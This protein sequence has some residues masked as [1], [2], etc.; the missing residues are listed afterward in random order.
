MQIFIETNSEKAITLNVVSFDT[1]E[2]VKEKF[3]NVRNIPTDQQHLF[4]EGKKLS[5]NRS[6]DHY[7]I[8]DQSTLVLKIGKSMIIFVETGYDKPINLDVLP[9]DTIADVK[10]MVFEERGIVSAQQKLYFAGQNLED[11]RTLDSYSIE[12][13][14]TLVLRLG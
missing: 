6:L 9:T 3:Q 10:S 14:S 7:G 2:T 4:F 12:K 8:E 1:I 11:N 5:D 13:E